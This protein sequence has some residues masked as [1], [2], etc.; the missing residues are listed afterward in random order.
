[1]RWLRRTVVFVLVLM[2]L[3]AG[4][5][6][7]LLHGSLSRL[8]GEVTLRGLAAPATLSRD[9][10]GTATINAG[11]RNDL[12]RALGY[13]HA[14]ERYFQMD[15]FRR[16][17]AG[18]LAEL[19]G[20]AALPLDRRHRLHRFRARATAALAQMPP[21]QRALL[22]A[23]SNGVNSGLADLSIRPW[24][25]LLLRQVPRPWVSEDSALAIY[26]MFFDLND[27]ENARELN[28]ARWS[29][30][31]PDELVQFLVGPGGEWDAP[32]QGAAFSPRAVP[33]ESVLDL[34]RAAPE[35]PRARQKSSHIATSSS[36]QIGGDELVGAGDTPSL[37]MREGIGSNNFA[38]GGALT[39]D[40]A[41]IVADDMHLSLRVPNI[42]FRARLT[43]TD[44]DAK[45]DLNG[46]TLPGA[47]GLV[48][49]SNGRIA[50][51]FTNSYGDWLDFVRVQRDPAD[52]Q[53][54]RVP[55]GW[56]AFEHH[57]E[58]LHVAGAPDEHLDV[59]DTRWGP[60]T[61]EDAD[62]TPLALAWTAHEPRALN[63]GLV[64]LARIDSVHAA[65]DL[66]PRIGM[67]VQN[68]V[69]GD[70]Q[71]H[72]G[73]TLTGNALPLRRNINALHPADWSQ[74]DTG[75]VGWLDPAQFP[76]IEDPT[77]ARLWSANARTVD[78]DWLALEGDGG[79]DLGARAQ[80]I[81]DDLRG[82]QRFAPS[83]LLAIQLDDRAV[84]LARWQQL[85]T[86]TLADTK[87]P[88]L[89]ELHKLTAHWS[90]KASVDAV[91]YR[92]VRSFR[93]KVIDA[94]LAPFT[95]AARARF[96][97]FDQPSAQSYEAPVWALLHA[98]PAHL[99]D[100][101]YANW[102]ALLLASAGDVAKE[103]SSEPGGL[104]A[105]SWGERNTVAIRHPL[106][107]VL[108]AFLARYL[109]M[110][111]QQLP[112]DRDMPRVQGVKFGASERFAIVPGHEDRSYL[113]MPGGQSG[114][115]LSP[116]HG[117]GHA[118]WANGTPT[119]LLPGPS[120]HQLTLRPQ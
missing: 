8:D 79:V 63:L 59:V 22:D 115:P 50:W 80:Q 105:R 97:E 88:A 48:A 68:F 36:V 57:K 51:G 90:G 69:V 70:A 1:M 12:A 107:S 78:G 81:R 47:P 87:D 55:D 35:L 84:F 93:A 37:G 109:D 62:G 25:Y 89:M 82:Q 23:Y 100:P 77:D 120:A 106:S 119:P 19:V 58:V 43:Y 61:A 76:R 6:W 65:L 99:L 60:L 114:H 18:E 16:M 86:Q 74:P 20:G 2:L 54:Y 31:M 71:G 110:P 85:L 56:A 28:L 98:K 4:T 112:G 15:L 73:W 102:D 30:V 10:L 116:F 66:A 26:A 32:L 52:A 103:L 40:G 96:P 38:V 27:S 34:R 104:A 14:Q 101:R 46:V 24:E 92:L 21:D 118:D 67:P 11:S 33:D 91:D 44:G 9:A 3:I 111:A 95:A 41:A 108:P 113:M 5:S 117:K 49:G 29:S 75:W 17:A 42:W 13:A 45:V 72:I 94:V 7:W 83:D 39:A 53:R 64:D